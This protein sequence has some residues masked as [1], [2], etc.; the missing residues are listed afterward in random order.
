MVQIVMGNFGLAEVHFL[1]FYIKKMWGLGAE[2]AL[3]L[4]LEETL[5][6]IILL[7]YGINIPLVPELAHPV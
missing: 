5:Y 2:E 1:V 4:M 7:I 3:G 6:A